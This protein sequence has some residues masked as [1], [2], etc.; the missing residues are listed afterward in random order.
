MH[1]LVNDFVSN[2]IGIVDFRLLY[3]RVPLRQ[4]FLIYQSNEELLKG[5]IRERLFRVQSRN[6]RSR[7]REREVEA[8]SAACAASPE[9]RQTTGPHASRVSELRVS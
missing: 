4:A 2:L 1:I 3:D 6:R 8:R 5:V 9:E 7:S